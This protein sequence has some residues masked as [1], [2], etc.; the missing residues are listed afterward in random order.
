MK[1]KTVYG[2]IAV[3]VVVALAVGSVSAFGFG[4]GPMFKG[5]N[6]LTDE[7]K[8]EMQAFQEDIQTAIDN[9]DYAEWKSLMESQLSE[10]NF[11]LIVEQNSKMTEMKDLRDQLKTAIENKDT[12]K[13]DELRTQ[14]HELMPEPANANGI[15]FAKG[16]RNGFEKGMGHG[17]G[18]GKCPFADSDAEDTE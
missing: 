9:N 2:I 14:M 10:D 13:A 12:A 1:N 17:M 11:N 16:E 5:G 15:G 7:E 6:D 18:N 4:F 8:A 3:I